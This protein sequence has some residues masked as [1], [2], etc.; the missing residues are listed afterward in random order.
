MRADLTVITI[1]IKK[2]AISTVNSTVN[3]VAL[4]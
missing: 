3:M 4:M 2:N 1:K